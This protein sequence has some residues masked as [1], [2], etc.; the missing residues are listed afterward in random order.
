MFITVII[1]LTQFLFSTPIA[2]Y[3]S[4]DYFISTTP[5]C[6][7]ATECKPTKDS[8]ETSTT[9]SIENLGA[10]ITLWKQTVDCNGKPTE[11]IFSRNGQNKFPWATNTLYLGRDGILGLD[12]VSLKE[13]TGEIYSRRFFKSINNNAYGI[14]NFPTYVPITGL[15][16]WWGYVNEEHPKVPGCGTEI[17]SVGHG[18]DKS[19]SEFYHDNYN[20]YVLDCRPFQDCTTKHYVKTIIKADTWGENTETYVF[21]K[22]TDPVTGKE[23]GLGIVR[24]R[25]EG[26]AFPEGRDEEFRLV[27]ETPPNDYTPCYLC[28][29]PEDPIK[30]P[31]DFYR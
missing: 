14:L 25:A 31:I 22:W 2:G 30:P 16:F 12:E 20:Y 27:V 3:S 11:L 19:R 9:G 15:T 17:E 7:S 5:T 24:W 18:D 28:P 8:G 23:E 10:Y 4:M 13:E 1:I 26:P 6:Q 21:A 29:T